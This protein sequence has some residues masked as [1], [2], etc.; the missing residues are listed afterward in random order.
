MSDENAHPNN[1]P[2]D[3]MHQT[4]GG[5]WG[6]TR[7]V[8]APPRVS[9]ATAGKWSA[10]SVQQ[11]QQQRTEGNVR[12][13]VES[14]SIVLVN[15]RKEDDS[16][17]WVIGYGY[18][19]ESQFRELYC[20]LE[21]CGIITARRG[22][23]ACFGEDRPAAESD[24]GDN[25]VA[26]RYESALYAQKALCQH[27]NFVSIGGG[28]MVMGVMP[29]SESDAAAKLGINVNGSS[30]NEAVTLAGSYNNTNNGRRHRELRTEADIMMYKDGQGGD[31]I[32]D[33][34]VN[35]S[36]DSLCGKVLG[37]FFMWD[38]QA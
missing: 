15:E 33:N 13:G 25:W 24:N 8:P 9:L 3:S 17:L 6:A 21:S 37:W 5:K 16:S 20:R 38:T 35:S 28:T 34:E 23:L 4:A 19:N 27:K 18:R 26:V 14:Q 22:G 11:Q 10:T 32:I 30:S 7:K 29:L 1:A 36:L 2:R 31:G 12:G